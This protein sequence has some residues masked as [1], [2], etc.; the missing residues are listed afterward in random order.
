K[1]ADKKPPI[2]PQPPLQAGECRSKV[3]NLYA[4]HI[5]PMMPHGIRG[6]LWDQ[7]ESGTAING[8]DQY[9]LM[10]A[11]IR[12]WR[13]EWG[14]G[15]FAFLYVQKPSGGGCAWDPADPVTDKSDKFTPL[16]AAVPSD[17]A[18]RETH[19]KIMQYPQTAMVT[20]SDLG[21]N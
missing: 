20:S 6:V 11:L 5:R 21:P 19:I 10:G 17:G 8:V 3:G 16:P 4:A 7:G 12:G 14:Q 1:K 13:K 2:K 9:T 18:Y 15:D